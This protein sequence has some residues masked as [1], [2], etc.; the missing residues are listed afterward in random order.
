MTEEESEKAVID[1]AIGRN[2][3]R[4]EGSE[5]FV[6]DEMETILDTIDLRKGEQNPSSRGTEST[7]LQ[8]FDDNSEVDSTNEADTNKS[9]LSEIAESLGVELS[10]LRRHFFIE[11]GNIHVENP[12]NIPP[13]F[14]LLGYCT[15]EN[16]RKNTTTFDNTEMKEKLINGEGVEIDGWGDFI[17]NA[18]RRGDIRDDPNTDQSRNKPFR[19]TRD[20]RESFL[21]WLN[22]NE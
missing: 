7:E 15:I 14:A 17:Y 19:L 22:D 6:S 16:E 4:I 3:I 2:Q 9:E 10:R 21:D 20:G 13:R 1:L 5:S 18:R 8:D 12:L 11:D